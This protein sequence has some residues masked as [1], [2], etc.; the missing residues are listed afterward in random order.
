MCVITF[1]AIYQN[2]A[3]LFYFDD[4]NWDVLN[5]TTGVHQGSILGFLLIIS[6][7]V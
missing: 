1:W 7:N 3:H 2:T 5:A 4:T 6:G